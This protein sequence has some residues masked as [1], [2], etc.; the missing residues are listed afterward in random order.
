MNIFSILKDNDKLHI[1][2][3]L[4]DQEICVCDLEAELGLKQSTLSNKLRALKDAKIIKI[5]KEKNWHYYSLDESFYRD[6]LKLFEYIQ[7]KNEHIVI[8]KSECK[9]I[10]GK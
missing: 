1:I 3:L 9:E 5:R 4:L 2:L 8:T 6:N 7:E 10:N